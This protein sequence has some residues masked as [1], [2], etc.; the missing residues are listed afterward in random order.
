MGVSGVDTVQVEHAK[1]ED[2]SRQQISADE[3]EEVAKRL[4]NSGG[5]F[6]I[7]QATP[8]DVDI[9]ARAEEE[10][11]KFFSR[12]DAEKKTYAGKGGRGGPT[13][14]LMLWGNGYSVYR[15]VRHQFHVVLG[16]ADA[17]Q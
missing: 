6:T 12:P 9:L 8:E 11:M 14:S 5:S 13:D 15:A 17:Q 7:L 16:D 3:N 1:T 2:P 10:W 4:A